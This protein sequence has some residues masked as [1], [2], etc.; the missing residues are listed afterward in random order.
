MVCLFSY[1]LLGGF[2]SQYFQHVVSALSILRFVHLMFSFDLPSSDQQEFHLKKTEGSFATGLCQS[3]WYREQSQWIR[4]L[5]LWQYIRLS[6]WLNSGIL[7]KYS[8]PKL[9]NVIL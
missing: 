8:M 3:F 9:Q 5:V 1:F 2:V 7:E 6:P 4:G